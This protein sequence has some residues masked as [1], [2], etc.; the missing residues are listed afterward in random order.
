MVARF[1]RWN[2][3]INEDKIQAIYFSHRTSPLESF[4]ALNGRDIP[5]VSCTMYLGVIFNKG[6]TWRLHI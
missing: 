5:F 1:R 4:L 3:E 2:I 6:I